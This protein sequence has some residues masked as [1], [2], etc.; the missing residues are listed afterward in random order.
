MTTGAGEAGAV[1]LVGVADAESEGGIP[2]QQRGL[3]A[4]FWIEAVLC[5]VGALL[6]IL[7]IV[8]SDWI[9]TVFRVDPD[10][11][12]GSVEWIVVVALLVVAAGLG[13]LAGREWRRAH[14]EAA[15]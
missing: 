8:H 6:A 4:T 11:G 1:N 2:M 5:V 9:E 13:T 12:N 3:R 10:Q 14:A 15:A 7:T